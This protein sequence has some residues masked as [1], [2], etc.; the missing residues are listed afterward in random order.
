MEE[1]IKKELENQT[2]LNLA[3][4]INLD[5]PV[6]DVKRIVISP[7][8]KTGPRKPS[9]LEFL[10]RLSPGKSLRTALD[11]IMMANCGALIVIDCP[12]LRNCFEGG[13]KVNC[14]FSPQKVAELAKMD[15]AIILS[16]DLR[17]IL[18]ANTLLTPDTRI[19]SNET[20]TRHMAAERTSCQLET[21][22]IAV[23]ERR[24]KISFFYEHKKYVLQD[25]EVLLSRATENLN[26]LEKQR[27]IFNDLLTN[28]NVLEITN[29]VSVG[30]VCSI[31]QRTE[32]IIRVMT[33]LKR[34]IIE[35]GN[36]GVIIQMRIRELFKGIDSLIEIVLKDYLYKPHQMKKILSSINF[37]GLLDSGTLARILFKQ[38]SDEMVYPKGYRLLEKTNLTEREITSLI[39]SFN[40]LGGI[41]EATDE[42][43][44][45]ILKQKTPSFKKE[46]DNL[47]EQIMLGKKI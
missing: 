32:M 18:F 14:R 16:S 46:F 8:I 24:G 12:N 40:N 26:I 17:K 30:D 7:K 3:E 39:A 21:P 27:E 45:K 34:Y 38:S 33:N 25:S 31:L 23:S 11:D 22:V 20:G 4:T 9:F 2:E 5:Q 28:L 44:N 1:E 29:L 41:L 42:D 19:P 10:S 37:D 13:F 36:E 47:K 43:L 35:L 15:G 6:K